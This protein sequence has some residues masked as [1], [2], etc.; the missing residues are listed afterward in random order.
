MLCSTI[1]LVVFQCAAFA[2]APGGDARHVWAGAGQYEDFHVVTPEN[3]SPLSQCAADAFCRYWNQATRRTITASTVNSGLINVWL[4]AKIITEEMVKPGELDGLSPEG[5]LTR[6]YTP[7][8]R[9]A[10]KGARKQLL[11]AGTTDQATLHGVYGFFAAAFGARWAAPGVT[12]VTAAEFTMKN[13]E[14]RADAAFA[15]REAGVFGQW[16][17]ATAEEFRRGLRLPAAFAPPPP[18]MDAFAAPL[19]PAAGEEASTAEYGSEAGADRIAEALAVLIRAG[20]SA[21]GETKA[22][23]ERAAWPPD[24][25]TWSLNA[26]DWMTPVAAAECAQRDA[27]E[28]SPAASVL[29]TAN[30][31]ASRL[32]ELFPDAP[33]RIHLLLPPALRRPP[34]TLCPAE[35]VV[36]QLSALDMDFSRP[37]EDRANAAF[38]DDL[39]GWAK[40]GGKLWVLDQAANR[41]DPRLPFPNLHAIPSNVLFCAQNGV[42]GIYALG[43]ASGADAPADLAEM[44]AYL[45]AQVLWNPDIAFDELLREYCD[46]YYGP[47]GAAVL[48]RVSMEETAVKASGKPLRGDDD[49]AWLDTAT[50]QRIGE[51]LEAV[52]ALPNL[53]PDMKPR[54]ESVLASVRRTSESR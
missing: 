34:K 31:V 13:V 9:Y 10:A 44:R 23:R 33:P 5:C 4:G 38:A 14:L 52:L 42:S 24:T 50:V 12:R 20:E 8:P 16:R 22:R 49:G 28:S 39:R 46:L 18:G 7:G 40:L 30:R 48:E 35:N 47:A 25:N 41:R 11:I 53:P 21:Q 26:L 19:R 36:V 37:M 27:Q 2:Q 45:W 17:G 43:G 3:P 6:T 1:A 29:F 15:F 51:K 32:A 54:V